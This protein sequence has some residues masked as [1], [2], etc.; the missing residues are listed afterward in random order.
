MTAPLSLKAPRAI[1]A[2]A[3]LVAALPFLA[4]VA[5]P[6]RPAPLGD[7]MA[8]A[9]ADILSAPCRTD[10]ECWRRIA[11]HGLEPSYYERPNDVLRSDCAHGD[12][13]ACAYFEAWRTLDAPFCETAPDDV[14]C[15]AY[16]HAE[17][18]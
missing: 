15:A 1:A 5:A 14:E 6:S 8:A 4:A 10:S 7:R 11:S 18:P 12:D 9:R 2:A 16:D 13:A 3:L 17:S